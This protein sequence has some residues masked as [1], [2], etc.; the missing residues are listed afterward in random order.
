MNIVKTCPPCNH[1]CSQSDTCPARAAIAQQ[2]T[3]APTQTATDTHPTGSL[4]AEFSQF[5]D[6][7]AHRLLVSLTVVCT[8][9]AVC[10]VGGYA[11]AKLV[12]LHG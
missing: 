7:I 5:V 12:L 10:G 1:D 4:P 9:A 8:I 11:Y 2:A 3:P 6:G